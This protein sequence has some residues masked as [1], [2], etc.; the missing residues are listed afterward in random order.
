M[1]S[2][3]ETLNRLTPGAVNAQLFDSLASGVEFL[4]TIASELA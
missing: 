4:E 3:A 2:I 1:L